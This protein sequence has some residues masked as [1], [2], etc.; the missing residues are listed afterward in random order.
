[1]ENPKEY[2]SNIVG[3]LGGKEALL[4]SFWNACC[5]MGVVEYLDESDPELLD[6]DGRFKKDVEEVSRSVLGVSMV[7][8][9]VHRA[10]AQVIVEMMPEA[11][12]TSMEVNGEEKTIQS[13]NDDEETIQPPNNDD[14]ETVQPPN[15]DDEETIQPPKNDGP[16]GS[17]VCCVEGVRE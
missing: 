1:M 3:T 6:W 9:P 11:W 7:I 2:I 14:K 15:N 10:T 12:V 13:L 17:R 8:D 4:E 5:K 16:S